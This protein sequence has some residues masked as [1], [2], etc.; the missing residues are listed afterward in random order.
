MIAGDSN[1]QNTPPIKNHLAKVSNKGS[2]C[3]YTWDEQTHLN[4]QH[5]LLE[6]EPPYTAWT[7]LE[8]T[9]PPKIVCQI[10]WSFSSRPWALF[11]PL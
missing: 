7:D 1:E 2:L 3:Q 11:F 9:S 6:S 4:M 5:G 10:L 8:E